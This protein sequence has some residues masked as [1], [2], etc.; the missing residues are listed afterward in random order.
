MEIYLQYCSHIIF[1]FSFS[2]SVKDFLPVNSNTCKQG[3]C[4]PFEKAQI[5][6]LISNSYMA[7]AIVI[8]FQNKIIV[9]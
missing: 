6:W 4:I 8:T 1:S 3:A 9:S 7:R 2:N 5:H